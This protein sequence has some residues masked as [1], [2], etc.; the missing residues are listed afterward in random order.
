MVLCKMR[1]ILY[2]LYRS[3]FCVIAGLILQNFYSFT[4]YM[5]SKEKVWYSFFEL[6]KMLLNKGAYEAVIMPYVLFVVGCMSYIL[7]IQYLVQ[8]II[9]LLKRSK[10]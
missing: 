8:C 1:E 3:A 4:V 9:I 6:Q 2:N 7:S 5:L 10:Q